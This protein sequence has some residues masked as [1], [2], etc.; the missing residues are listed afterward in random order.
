MLFITMSAISPGE[1][2]LRLDRIFTGGLAVVSK[3]DH[4]TLTLSLTLPRTLW[5]DQCF[6]AVA[7]EGS[8]S[9]CPARVLCFEGIY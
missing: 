5:G 6:D 3:A 8:R 7:C 1:A 2:W 4:P 9:I